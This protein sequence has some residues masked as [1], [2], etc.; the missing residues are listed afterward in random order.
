MAQ[1]QRLAA[2]SKGLGDGTGGR[3]RVIIVGAGIAGLAAADLLRGAGHDVLLLEAQNRVGGRIYTVRE[4]LDD[5]LFAEM[6]AMRIPKKHVL[7]MAYVDEQFNLGT[8]EFTMNNPMTYIRLQGKTVRRGKFKPADFD[9]D[10]YDSEELGETPEDRLREA[11]RSLFDRVDMDGDQ[12][13]D[14]ITKTH[15]HYSLRG[16]LIDAGW[17]QGAIELLG[18]L[19]NVESRMNSSFVEFLHHEYRSTF[20]DMVYIVGGMDRLPKAFLDRLEK[21]TGSAFEIRYCAVLEEIWQYERTVTALYR[22]DGEI[23]NVEAD[24]LIVTI[25]FSLMRHIKV[26]PRLSPRKARAI[27]QVKYDAASKIFM[28]VSRRF[29]E[30]DD[31][32]YGGGTV[33]DTSIRNVFYPERN[34]FY[35]EHGKETGKGIL[36]ASYTWGNDST[37]LASLSPDDLTRLI[38]RQLKAIHPTIEQDFER[39]LFH[40]WGRDP[41]AGGVGVLLEPNQ[42][43]EIFDDIVKPEGR[44]HFAGDHCSRFETRWIQGALESAIQTARAVHNA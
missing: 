16:F 28:Q 40:H 14:D 3:K 15:D 41:F 33:T 1:D 30:D 19:A 5:D 32:I 20:S 23:H 2:I 35:P 38:K 37:Y 10:I 42:Y 29:W 34:M 11:L 36:L 44:I 31:K 21:A 12:A 6:G 25:P 18:L 39:T 13:W 4:G 9:Y 24:Y 43:S 7:T 17:S 8:K 27:R 26:K 22:T